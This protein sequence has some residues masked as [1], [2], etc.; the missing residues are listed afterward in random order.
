MTIARESA[1]LDQ[2]IDVLGRVVPGLSAATATA[3]DTFTGS[4]GLD[5]LTIA[6]FGVEL[7]KELGVAW[8]LENWIA[9]CSLQGTD[10]LGALAS[11]I[12]TGD[13]QAM[14]GA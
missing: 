4:L 7:T 11:W 5:S 12:A 13:P 9:S 14:P 6:R 1:C 3:E 2:V 10:S 8:P